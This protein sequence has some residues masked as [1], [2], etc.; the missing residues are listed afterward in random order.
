MTT[1]TNQRSLTNL[2]RLLGPS[3]DHG[4]SI[5][6]FSDGGVLAPYLPGPFTFL[7]GC[8]AAEVSAEMMLRPCSSHRAM[9]KPQARRPA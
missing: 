9:L 3:V 2:E 6:R 8:L 7:C 1:S 4:K 5:T